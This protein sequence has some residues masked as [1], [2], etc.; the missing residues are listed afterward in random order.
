MLDR[1]TVYTLLGVDVLTEQHRR[2]Y[3]R[4]KPLSATSEGR[5][6]WAP[7]GQKGIPYFGL[8]WG[9]KTSRRDSP[10]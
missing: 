6:L 9:C 5:T 7:L 2:T 8:E 10:K 3:N 1:E 4:V